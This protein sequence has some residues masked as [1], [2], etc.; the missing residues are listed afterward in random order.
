MNKKGS[1]TIFLAIVIFT[2]ISFVL[3]IYEVTRIQILDIEASQLAVFAGNS[4][5]AGYDSALKNEYGIFARD[6]NYCDLEYIYPEN[7]IS[8]I[9]YGE[10]EASEVTV[11]SDAKSKKISADFAYYLGEN[12]RGSDLLNAEV[13]AE[14]ISNLRSSGAREYLKSEIINYTKLNLPLTKINSIFENYDIFVKIGKTTAFEDRKNTIVK[15]AGDLENNYSKLYV[16]LDG[17]DVSSIYGESTVNNYI[18]RLYVSEKNPN[19]LPPAMKKG[20]YLDLSSILLNYQESYKS[21]LLASKGLKNLYLKFKPLDIEYNNLKS[22]IEALNSDIARISRNLSSLSKQLTNL[23]AES[24]IEI[25]LR[26]Q[27]E[28]LKSELREL[29]GNKRNLQM[30]LNIVAKKREPLYKKIKKK[31]KTIDLA[32]KYINKNHFIFDAL[33][34]DNP[35]NV[36]LSDDYGNSIGIEEK[37]NSFLSNNK[38][39]KGI[40]KTIRKE[41]QSLSLKIDSFIEKEEDKKDDY[42]NG[43]YKEAERTLNKIKKEYGSVLKESFDEKGNLNLM[44]EKVDANIHAIESVYEEIEYLSD[45]TYADL[46]HQFKVE[47]VDENDLKELNQRTIK[48]DDVD[49]FVSGLDFSDNTSNLFVD[50]IEKVISSLASYKNVSGLSYENALNTDN[51]SFS[52]HYKALKNI[53]ENIYSFMKSPL[54]SYDNY[55]LPADLKSLGKNLNKDEYK[56]N[57]NISKDDISKLDSEKSN[58]LFSD[59]AD[60]LSLEGIAEKILISEYILSMFKAYPDKFLKR[61]SMSGYKLKEHIYSTELEYI[62]SGIE[63]SDTAMAYMITSIF[64]IRMGLNTIFLLIDAQKREEII[65]F[66]NIIAGWWSFGSGTIIMSVII[67]FLW[68][69][70]ESG[71]DVMVLIHGGDVPLFKTRH[72]WYTS[73]DGLTANGY[74][75]MLDASKSIISQKMEMIIKE[76][77]KN[78]LAI[79]EEM[80]EIVGDVHKENVARGMNLIYTK[81]YDASSAEIDRL[82]N[83]FDDILV[84]AVSNKRDGKKILENYSVGNDLSVEEKEIIN[85]TRK[86]VDEAYVEGDYDSYVKLKKEVKDELAVELHKIKESIKNKHFEFV[87]DEIK[88]ANSKIKNL[89][90]KAEDKSSEIVSRS[91]DDIF[92]DMDKQVRK[93]YGEVSDKS[94]LSL[95]PRLD[96]FDYLRLMLLTNSDLDDVLDRTVDMIDINLS[97]KK[98][99]DKPKSKDD[100]MLENYTYEI[101]FD[102]DFKFGF[103]FLDISGALGAKS[104]DGLFNI[105]QEKVLSYE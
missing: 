49:R 14:G 52:E 26:S 95:V 9:L 71:V 20:E 33:I 7:D 3:S 12:L 21:I 56:L 80:M 89:M 104:K 79:S 76:V 6:L 8:K 23:P 84:E 94:K 57:S 100:L 85:R 28:A 13:K 99:G 34:V 93:R 45:K 82:D 102:A 77:P 63:S 88:K 43:T 70:I 10:E 78:V 69:S 40:I 46:A 98:S 15:K 66:A 53:Y 74:M 50:K 105:R 92:D 60:V 2:L 41:G 32:G 67:S 83:K 75:K 24:H 101:K 18:N 39:V 64:A 38:T 36:I 42:I 17:V 48:S 73:L 54:M 68:A 4:V 30:T 103:K 91:I 51:K 25:N 58:K 90:K 62:I 29:R 37:Y 11:K 35:D 1:V 61:E 81:V 87:D 86:F 27:I 16:F 97:A 55:S 44:E 22:D 65:S 47:G 5:L 31:M 96:Y 19:K 72:T 59:L